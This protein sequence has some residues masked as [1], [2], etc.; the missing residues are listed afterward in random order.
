[1]R[2]DFNSDY[3]MHHGILGM[4]WG[5]RRY[6][7]EDGSL[8]ELGKKRAE[9]AA[10]R[11]AKYDENNRKLAENYNKIYKVK[12]EKTAQK[13]IDKGSKLNERNLKRLQKRH[14]A[15]MREADRWD[16]T[17]IGQNTINDQIRQIQMQEATRRHQ[18]IVNQQIQQAN[19]WHMDTAIQ[20]Q[21]MYQ[22]MM[23]L[24]MF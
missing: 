15:Y 6:Q 11:Q 9:K 17:K 5:I 13:M 3:L 18:E 2:N 8:T 7:N 16:V 22:Q 4:K 24:H 20:N 19:Q 23:Q 12:A 1:M 10:R 21:I 14:D